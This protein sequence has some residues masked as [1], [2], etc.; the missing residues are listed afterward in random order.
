MNDTH[1]LIQ[2]A[3]AAGDVA[4]LT[5]AARAGVALPISAGP[6]L[7]GLQ[8]DGVRTDVA[9]LDEQLVVTL[10]PSVTA[11]PFGQHQPP[12]LSTPKHRR[13]LLA[14][15]AATR[16]PGGGPPYPGSWATVADVLTTAR[17]PSERSGRHVLGS[18]RVLA[19]LG[20]AVL[21]D[22]GE[23]VRPGPRLAAWQDEWT[24]TEL[25]VLLDRV[26]GS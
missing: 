15:L 8:H 19:D 11:D 5:A 23:A 22:D 24:R 21:S 14:L 25:P 4:I 17:P 10:D 9:D 2:D 20:F 16:L 18:L 26:A 3:I 6:V 13:A 12:V 7:A 1:E